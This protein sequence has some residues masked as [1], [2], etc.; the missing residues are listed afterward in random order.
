MKKKFWIFWIF[1]I[2]EAIFGHLT[3]SFCFRAPSRGR[4]GGGAGEGAFSVIGILFEME[5]VQ[6]L[7]AIDEFVPII[8]LFKP[9]QPMLNQPT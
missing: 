3:K 1:W 7:S 8:K 6:K 2:F 9:D 5:F 4:G